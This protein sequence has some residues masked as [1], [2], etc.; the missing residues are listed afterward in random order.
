MSVSYATHLMG[1]TVH[2]TNDRV[3]SSLLLPPLLPLI[4]T[5]LCL[6]VTAN[7]VARPLP[8]GVELKDKNSGGSI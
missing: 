8:E 5:D 1:A 2:L 6:P 3:T 7:E 4:P